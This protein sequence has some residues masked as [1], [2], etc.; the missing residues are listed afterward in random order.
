ML[1]SSL[2]LA[3]TKHL[4]TGNTLP[5]LQTTDVDELVIPNPDVSKQVEIVKYIYGIKDKAKQ[6]QK[7]GD[8]LLEEAK[9]KIEKMIIG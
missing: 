5:R 8:A 7:E 4:M 3:Q 9:Q 1:R 2:T 6:L